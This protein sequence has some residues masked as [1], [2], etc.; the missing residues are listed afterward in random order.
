MNLADLAR[1]ESIKGVVQHPSNPV[2]MMQ[3]FAQFKKQLQNK[4][5]RAIVER[6][7]ETGQMTQEQFVMLKQQAETLS[8]LL[9]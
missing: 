1:G 6:L 4:D 2:Q 3:A 5:P 8:G 9:K 7:L